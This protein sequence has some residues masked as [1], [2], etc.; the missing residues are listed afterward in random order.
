[1]GNS[2]KTNRRQGIHLPRP[3]EQLNDQKK[4]KKQQQKQ[5]QEKDAKLA[6]NVLCQTV[7]TLDVEVEEREV[8]RAFENIMQSIKKSMYVLPNLKCKKSV[9]L[10]VFSSP[11]IFELVLEIVGKETSKL[12]VAQKEVIRGLMKSLNEVKM[13]L[14]VKKLATKHV[15]LIAAISFREFL[16]MVRVWICKL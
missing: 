2:K 3:S 11:W 8:K 14:K 15:L 7:V 6:I 1:M 16:F 4:K 5:A 12:V 9:M 13:P 10:K